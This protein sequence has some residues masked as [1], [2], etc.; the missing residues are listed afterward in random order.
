MNIELI[1]RGMFNASMAKLN[2][3]TYMAYRKDHPPWNT[4][5]SAIFVVR[6]DLPARRVLVG[7]EDPRLFVCR[8]SLMCSYNTTLVGGQ[9]FIGLAQLGRAGLV[10][11]S[12]IYSYGEGV[13]KNWAFFDNKDR[14]YA[15]YSHDPY[16]I[17][18]FR[19]NGRI[20]PVY[21]TD[22]IKW[23]FGPVRGGTPPVRVG[24]S[25]YTF[26]HSS[27]REKH[28]GIC[29]GP[30]YTGCL[31]FSAKA[32]FE[33]QAY[34]RTPLYKP[35]RNWDLAIFPGGATYEKGT[36]ALAC[37]RN[38]EDTCILEF[39]HDEVE[40]LLCDCQTAAP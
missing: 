11:K 31:K 21:Q 16:T 37:G 35:R 12:R 6:D 9:C 25:Y 2:G 8:G 14:L 36:W 34:T 27:I 40:A 13:Q 1:K 32:P 26:F 23:D 5:R 29:V 18:W 10:I 24:D 30:Y 22:G 28:V 20:D 33:P 3:S 4:G 19:V 15:I 7:A 17:I 39:G 38:N